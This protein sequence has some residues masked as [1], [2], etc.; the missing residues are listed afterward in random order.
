MTTTVLDAV[1]NAA[2]VDRIPGCTAVTC[3]SGLLDS[4]VADVLG[5][6]GAWST[7]MARRGDRTEVLI[8]PASHARVQRA[9]DAVQAA[10]R[11]RAAAVAA[12]LAGERAC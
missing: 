7:R 1:A 2:A 6:Y 10:I 8:C 4:E 3:R 12:I 5:S 9:L 11:I